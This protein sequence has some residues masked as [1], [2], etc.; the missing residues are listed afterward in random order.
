VVIGGPRGRDGGLTA[1]ETDDAT[2][3]TA[4]GDGQVF[5]TTVDRSGDSPQTTLW[6]SQSSDITQTKIVV[7][8][9][10]LAII[11]WVML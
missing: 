7:G 9:L 3:I 2:T 6:A 4:S 8:L 5:Q 1:R 11:A 10:A